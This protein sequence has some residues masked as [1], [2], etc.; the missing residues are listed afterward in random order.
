MA[1]AF[2]GSPLFWR[3][4][5]C[6]LT[7]LGGVGGVIFGVKNGGEDRVRGGVDGEGGVGCRVD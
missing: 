7:W 4:G 5:S 6:R 1:A 3:V 2:H